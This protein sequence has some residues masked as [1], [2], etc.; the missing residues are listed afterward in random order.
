[1]D[2]LLARQAEPAR[3]TFYAEVLS[4]TNQPEDGPLAWGNAVRFLEGV[5]A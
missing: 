2:T 4:A 5:L 3:E 1:V